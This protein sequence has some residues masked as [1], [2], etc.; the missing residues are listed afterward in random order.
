MTDLLKEMIALLRSIDARL[1]RLE[2]KSE[3][4]TLRYPADLDGVHHVAE[5]RDR[6]MG[7]RR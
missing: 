7:R 4:E 3:P 2:R 5:P 6:I 1:T